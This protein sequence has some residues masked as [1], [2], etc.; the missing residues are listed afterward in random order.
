MNYKIV[1]VSKN[2]S[3]ANM[4]SM[5]KW[6]YARVNVVAFASFSFYTGLYCYHLKYLHFFFGQIISNISS[7]ICSL[8]CRVFEIEFDTYLTPI[9]MS[10]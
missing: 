9:S 8:D 3:R 1:N 5:F 6:I 7:F 4:N 10:N 2:R